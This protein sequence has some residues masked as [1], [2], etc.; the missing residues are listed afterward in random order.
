MEKKKKPEKELPAVK[1][2]STVKLAIPVCTDWPQ[3]C[4]LNAALSAKNCISLPRQTQTDVSART[5][6]ER[7][8]HSEF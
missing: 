3:F 4:C 2:I 8:E 5:H 7:R 1:Y 6:V